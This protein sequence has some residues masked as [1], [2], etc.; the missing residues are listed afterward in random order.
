[1]LG[2]GG[3]AAESGDKQANISSMAGHPML[4]PP[5]WRSF[6]LCRIRHLACA[7]PLLEA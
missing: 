1:M 2:R 5:R 6:G 4:V 7:V 3:G